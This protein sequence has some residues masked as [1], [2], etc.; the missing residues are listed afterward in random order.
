[1]NNKPVSW[2]LWDLQRIV[3]REEIGR[4]VEDW[5]WLPFLP[6]WD[7]QIGQGAEQKDESHDE[8]HLPQLAFKRED[9]G[10]LI[11]G[12]TKYKFYEF[13]FNILD[14]TC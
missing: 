12:P 1:M 2:C 14:E 9:T 7:A 6:A 10:D 11:Y 5:A 8:R 4:S 13:D 3:G